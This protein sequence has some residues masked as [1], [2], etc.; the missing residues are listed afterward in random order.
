LTEHQNRGGLALADLAALLTGCGGAASGR[1]GR[2]VLGWPSGAGDA[3]ESRDSP[4]TEIKPANVRRLEG[5]L[6]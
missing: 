3:G 1:A 5:T 6:P 4:L 2:A